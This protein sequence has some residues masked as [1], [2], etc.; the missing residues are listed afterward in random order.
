MALQ[1]HQHTDSL[2]ERE[3]LAHLT[4]VPKPK[5]IAEVEREQ[6]E[7]EKAE[8]K[9]AE[10]KRYK[11]KK[12]AEAAAKRQAEEEGAE[13]SAEEVAEEVAEDPE[14]PKSQA[15]L[16][17]EEDAS[18]GDRRL[19]QQAKRQEQEDR[20]ASLVNSKQRIIVGVKG[21]DFR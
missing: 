2:P 21:K 8:K 17:A 19:E 7:K 20:L 1:Y 11:A 3:L 14:P 15:E 12:K 9:K 18:L 5:S 4:P 13:G 10:H 16:Q 6:A